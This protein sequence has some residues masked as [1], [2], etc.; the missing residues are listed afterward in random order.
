MEDNKRTKDNIETPKK[1]THYSAFPFIDFSGFQVVDE[2]SPMRAE[3]F[4]G[5]KLKHFSTLSI[6]GYCYERFGNKGSMIQDMQK[7][8]TLDE[9]LDQMFDGALKK[10]DLPRLLLELSCSDFKAQGLG[11]FKKAFSFRDYMILREDADA[12]SNSGSINRDGRYKKA[13]MLNNLGINTPQVVL[14]RSIQ[15]SKSQDPFESRMAYEVQEKVQ[16]LPLSP[17][18]LDGMCLRMI[19]SSLD[20]SPLGIS[21]HEVNLICD[22]FHQAVAMQRALTGQKHLP[23][24]LDDALVLTYLRLDSDFHGEN[25]LYDTKSGYGFLDLSLSFMPKFATIDDI[26]RHV[27]NSIAEDIKSNEIINVFSGLIES[28]LCLKGEFDLCKESLEDHFPLFVYNGLIFEQ[29]RKYLCGESPYKKPPV[30]LKDKE[31]F[32]IFENEFFDR[33]LFA[34]PFEDIIT[35]Y[36]GLKNGKIQALNNI[37]NRYNLPFNFDFN[38]TLNQEDFFEAFN[39]TAF[40]KDST[41]PKYQSI[42]FAPAETISDH[43]FECEFGE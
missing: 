36:D 26:I 40:S 21:R 38:G 13:R 1:Q 34:M 7:L 17:F 28:S 11:A 29:A 25:I 14:A 5:P 24:Y 3:Y 37:R 19:N 15:P 35:L 30:N 41:N 9:A 20:F 32:E 18:R 2:D 27:N 31:F 22:S 23:K 39:C 12:T 4:V 33:N 16:G 10:E 6:P 8:P 42:K 43:P